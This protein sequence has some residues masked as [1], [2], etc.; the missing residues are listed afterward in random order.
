MFVQRN[1][2]E[3]ARSLDQVEGACKACSNKLGV[4]DD[5]QAMGLVLHDDMSGH[6]SMA[7]YMEN[8]FEAITF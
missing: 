8:G 1:S 5:V 3:K 2:Y 4:L 7:R 6:P